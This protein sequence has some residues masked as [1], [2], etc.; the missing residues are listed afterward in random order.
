MQAPVTNRLLS[1]LSP[2]SRNLLLAMCTEISLPIRTPLFDAEAIPDFAYFMTSGIAS[3][4]TYMEDGSTAEVEII[5]R[6]GIVGS[7]FLMGP[8]RVSTTCFMQMSGSGL[9]IRLSDL[10]KVFRSNEEVR[11]R[12][13]EFLQERTL[14]LSQIAA[15]NRL[16]E[17]EERLARWLL[18]A[19][20][21]T[22][23]ETL[24]FTQEFL[25]QMLGA[26]RTTVTVVAGA[27]QRSG[28]IEYKRGR[29]KILNRTNLESTACECYRTIRNL[30]DNLYSRALSQ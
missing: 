25:A 5:G 14:A 28:L 15:C 16:H 6:E 7:L 24:D 13:L 19:H 2:A 20:D 26:R 11:D 18:M 21:R 23:G 8:G 29:V 17:A 1:V 22:Q 10:Q 27:L 3:V 12:I 30:L 4:V 9:R